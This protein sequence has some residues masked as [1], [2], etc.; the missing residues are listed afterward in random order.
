MEIGHHF[1]TATTW[2]TSA[3]SDLTSTAFWIHLLEHYRYPIVILGALVEGEMV[4]ILSGAAAYHGYMS[5]SF[6]ILTAFLGAFIHDHLLF[7]LGRSFGER[8]LNFSPRW[9]RRIEKVSHWIQK[10]DQYFIMSFRF[11]YG[12]RTITP[13]LVGQSRIRLRRYSR[14]V[15]LSALIWAIA[16]SGFGYVGA[17]ALNV[18]AHDFA[19]YKKYIAVAILLGV[20]FVAAGISLYKRYR[21]R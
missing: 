14:L 8:L 10:Y 7:F 20:A 17:S 11:I 5:L 2:I 4:L 18:L 6:V 16:V 9:H 3:L 13:L 21:R 15:S 19:H 1:H 12:L